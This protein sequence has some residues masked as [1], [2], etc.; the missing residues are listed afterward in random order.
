MDGSDFDD[1]DIDD[2]EVE[3]AQEVLSKLL[4][5]SRATRVVQEESASRR[6]RRA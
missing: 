3:E 6:R 2:T 1:G 5:D 4:K